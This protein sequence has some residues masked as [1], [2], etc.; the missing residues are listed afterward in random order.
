MADITPRAKGISNKTLS[1]Y[2]FINQSGDEV[3]FKADQATKVGYTRGATISNSDMA[4][5]G[6]DFRA[7]VDLGIPGFGGVSAEA[8]SQF[9][10]E[11]TTEEMTQTAK[12]DEVSIIFSISD[13]M[14]TGLSPQERP[15]YSK[16]L[17]VLTQPRR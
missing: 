16:Y 8:G 15:D 5:I 2:H 17:W 13:Q 11:K 10:W 6:I 3:D 14:L 4:H 12:T 7:K 1:V 9:Q